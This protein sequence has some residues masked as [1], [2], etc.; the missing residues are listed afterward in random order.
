MKM[1]TRDNEHLIMSFDPQTIEH[2]GVKM[3]S[4][5][6]SAIAELIANA[7]DAGSTEVRIKLYDN[8]EGKK[9]EV[10]DDGYGMDFED[11]N[12]KFLRIGRNRRIDGAKKSPCGT[13]KAT[14]KKGLG[15][16][17]LFGIG[18]TIK[19]I[20]IKK[21]TGKKYIFIWIGTN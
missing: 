17:A 8:D 20:T 16:L 2:L 4:R 13:R 3:Y 14:G 6:P 7:Y 21:G 5:I 11:I 18:G 19:I 1:T 12:D 9:I 10:M 15:K